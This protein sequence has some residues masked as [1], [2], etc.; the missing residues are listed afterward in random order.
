MDADKLFLKYID[1][2]DDAFDLGVTPETLS[3]LIRSNKT[4]PD[5][6]TKVLAA[7]LKFIRSKKNPRAALVAFVKSNDFKKAIPVS[8]AKEKK[9]FDKKLMGEFYFTAGYKTL[10][11]DLSKAEYKRLKFVEHIYAEFKKGQGPLSKSGIT[12][13]LIKSK[14]R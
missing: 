13:L 1:V 5:V 12:S 7:S 6:K 3:K 8:L 10:L 9:F 2:I 11:K 14:R 4:R